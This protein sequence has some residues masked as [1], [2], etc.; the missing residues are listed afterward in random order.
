M[1]FLV[2]ETRTDL[3][4]FHSGTKKAPRVSGGLSIKE[5]SRIKSALA[6]EFVLEFLDPASGVD[7][8]LF[9][10]VDRV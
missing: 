10:G 9:S 2:G 6:A 1:N 5:N 8:A 3:P 4:L 7:K